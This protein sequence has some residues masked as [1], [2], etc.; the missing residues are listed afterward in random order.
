MKSELLFFMLVLTSQLLFSQISNDAVIITLRSQES[1][2][3]DSLTAVKIDS[4]LESARNNFQIDSLPYIHAFR[5]FVVDEL[6]L[7]TNAGW[8]NYWNQG[9]LRTGEPFID[10][11][12]EFYNLVA[13]DTPRFSISPYLLT[14]SQPLNIPLLTELFETHPD[15]IYAEVNGIIGDGDNIELVDKDSLLDIAFSIGRFDCPA[16]CIY[17]YYWYV[18]VYLSNGSYFP[19]LEEERERDFSQ[20]IL[21]RWNIPDRYA[22]TMFQNVDSI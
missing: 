3:L 14:Y 9:F 16:G 7:R 4:A 11:L 19:N 15:I 10:S 20:P 22:M 21:Y 18:S 1:I 13:V 6:V 17:R 12:N 8:A 2:F 5:D